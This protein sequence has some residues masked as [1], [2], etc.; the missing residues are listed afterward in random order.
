MSNDTF[1]LLVP[2]EIKHTCVKARATIQSINLGISAIIAVVIIADDD[3]VI[4]TRVYQLEADSYNNW[5]SDDLYIQ[6]YVQQKLAEEV[7]Q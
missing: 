5:G 7:N 3:S 4:D 6:Q 1:P 2:I